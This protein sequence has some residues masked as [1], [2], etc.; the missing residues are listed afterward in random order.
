MPRFAPLPRL[1][2]SL[3]ALIAPLSLRSQVRKD[4]P[5]TDWS[6]VEAVL[7]RKGAQT[8]GGV[9]RFSFPRSDLTVTVRGV[10]LR[11]AFA[12]GSWSAFR[13]EG[14]GRATVMGDLVLTE[15]EVAPV[16]RELQRG[17]VEQS[18]LHNHVLGEQPRI[19]YM[20]MSAHGEA[21]K[22]A[23][24]I[25]AALALTGTPLDPP[26]PPAM[27]AAIDLD[28][29]GVATALGRTGK[30]NGGVYQV[31]VPRAEKI[32]AHG[33]EITPA[34]GMA[35]VINFQ[36]TGDGKAAINGDFAMLASEVNP[37]IR[38]LIENGIDVVALHSHLLDESPRLLFMHFWANDDALKLARG[39][40]IALDRTNAAK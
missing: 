5:A 39:L 27:A 31:S 15:D 40:R 1:A 7:G 30:V 22:I 38:A 11:P 16:M 25:R 19:M 3:V 6:M 4:A 24:T 18:A 37:V 10:K 23:A 34:M 13:D 33:M 14:N 2:L 9:N 36:P 26:A 28:T 8:P 20:H 35:T 12:L 32:L 29:I 17:G 21:R